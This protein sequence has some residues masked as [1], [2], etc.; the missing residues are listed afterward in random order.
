MRAVHFWAII[1]TLIAGGG[2][3][4]A[5]I[6]L[7]TSRANLG[8]PGVG[9]NDAI[10][11]GS[12]GPSGTVVVPSTT[13]DQTF[14]M[15]S[16]GGK[17]ATVE[18]AADT[19]A[20]GGANLTVGA[21]SGL[22]SVFNS[23][24]FPITT[25]PLPEFDPFI[26]YNI[27]INF[28]TPV[29][30]AGADILAQATLNL[31]P[32]QGALGQFEVVALGRNSDGT[33]PTLGFFFFNLGDS[34]TPTSGFYGLRS[35]SG[36]VISTIEFLIQFQSQS[37]FRYDAGLTVNRVDFLTPSAAPEPSTLIMGATATLLGL[38][39]AF[40]RHRRMRTHSRA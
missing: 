18:S 20:G 14:P 22:P 39:S 21:L 33:M 32:G 13:Q 25:P 30:A 36:P 12:L 27:N 38:G 23:Q 31:Q 16:T 7:V 8:G 29:S 28:S 3:L 40:H 19:L 11:W 26:T 35:D 10:N 37:R 6:V 34:A 9:G 1:V 2:E 17:S 15:V 24:H 4:R 5:G